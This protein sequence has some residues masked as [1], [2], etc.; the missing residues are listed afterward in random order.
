MNLKI[1]WYHKIAHKNKFY[2]IY[3]NKDLSITVDNT[4]E[5]DKLGTIA[6]FLIG[7][8]YLD[9]ILMHKYQITL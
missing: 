5:S 2:G 6:W 8:N 4:L 7:K 9:N 1:I 3:D